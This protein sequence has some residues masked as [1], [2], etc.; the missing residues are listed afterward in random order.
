MEIIDLQEARLA[1]ILV[2]DKKRSESSNKKIIQLKDKLVR[3][4]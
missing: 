2:G 4:E 1:Y 3:S